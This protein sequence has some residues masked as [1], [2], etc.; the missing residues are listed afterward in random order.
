MKKNLI[1]Q[2]I[3]FFLSLFIYLSNAQVNE[4]STF[5]K[6]DNLP[7]IKEDWIVNDLTEGAKTFQYSPDIAVDGNGNYGIVWIDTRN[8]VLQIF[9]QFYNSNDEKLGPNILLSAKLVVEDSENPQISCNAKG[10]FV[11]AWSVKNRGIFALRLNNRGEKQS[12]IFLI[13]SKEYYKPFSIAVNSNGDLLVSWN[14]GKALAKLFD[15]SG[16][17]LS[18]NIVL[19][20]DQPLSSIVNHKAIAADEKEN[21]YVVWREEIADTTS[22]EP[23]R[24]MLQKIDGRGAKEGAN[25]I[26]MEG[27]EHGFKTQ[28]ARNN[29]G[30]ISVSCLIVAGINH[31]FLTF[32][33]Y[34]ENLESF[35]S[36]IFSVPISAYF[37]KNAAGGFNNNFLALY[38]LDGYLLNLRDYSAD[39]QS[40]SNEFILDRLPEN[41]QEI[42]YNAAISNVVNNHF[43]TVYGN[44]RT[45][46][47]YYGS[48]D[49]FVR[50]YDEN[51]I[52]VGAAQ[53]VN[54]DQHSSW[55]N[56]PLVCYN[57]RGCSL[58][59]WQDY[60]K[61]NSEIYARVFDASYN[62]LKESIKVNDFN[63]GENSIKGAKI[64]KKAV[65][66]SDGSFIL[67]MKGARDTLFL[68]T[69]NGKGERIG[70][71]RIVEN[72]HDH[73]VEFSLGANDKDEI[74]I[75]QFYYN[76]HNDSD[77]LTAVKYNHDLT[78]LGE[79]K[80]ILSIP[81]AHLD[82]KSASISV[83]KKLNI[84]FTWIEKNYRDNE[85]NNKIFGRLFDENG[86]ILFDTSPV[87]TDESGT[88]SVISNIADE[89]GN[90][91]IAWL[92]SAIVHFKRFYPHSADSIFSDSMYCSAVNSIGPYLVKFQNKKALAV[93]TDGYESK[94]YFMNDVTGINQS[95]PLYYFE[96]LY[97]N[98]HETRVSN[99]AALYDDK[100]LFSYESNKNG[101]TAFDIW[102][103]VQRTEFMD[104]DKEPYR[105]FENN[106][107]L[108]SNFPNPFNAKTDIA[109]DIFSPHRVKIIIYDVLGRRVRTLLDR[110]MEKGYYKISFDAGNLPS[111][112]Y[113]CRMKAS[114]RKM[115]KMLLVK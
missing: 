91:M 26:V 110:D 35:V 55:Q 90:V 31:Y 60:R 8:G 107:V 40:W 20:D 95:K 3:L 83:N 16:N 12:D 74:L 47:Q 80:V 23:A 99:S 89:E 61:S 78:P 28:I 46:N 59:A 82:L 71:N 19:S 34:S 73:L 4:N 112:V 6:G 30:I 101:G 21:F 85:R 68:Q 1:L 115:I 111:G 97:D 70:E 64:V 63:L 57:N 62:P 42:F 109:F 66:L 15:I 18:E 96:P 81:L 65:S 108:Y 51:Y 36:D 32:R 88:V 58:I 33:N 53:K 54:D 77:E 43:Y 9:A 114:N 87:S 10:D 2:K 69:I 13:D 104:F 100:L 41:G 38:T 49:I 93:W 72:R 113:F 84:F 56:D 48:G 103:N 25:I 76:D 5:Q 45:D 52:S 92:D 17:A 11:A 50:K 27:V 22:G 7:L 94:I 86:M 79:E 24:F 102:A 29:E 75:A 39:G 105:R 14:N 37:F 67:L 106:D 98:W 44:I